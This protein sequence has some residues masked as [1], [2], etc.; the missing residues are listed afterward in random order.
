MSRWKQELEKVRVVHKGR[1]LPKHV[2]EAARNPASALH[3]KFEW[4][5]TVA[6]QAYRLQQ[7]GKLIQSVTFLPEGAKEAIRAYVSLS[8]DR[9]S[10][11]GFRATIDV[12]SDAELKAQ[13]IADAKNE[14]LGFQQRYDRIRKVVEMRPVFRA[15]EKT[16]KKKKR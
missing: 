10:R 4:D 11:S 8:S 2:V 7:A 13:L 1:L 14:L 5:D 15:I 16:V 6:A 12:L 9:M 3:S